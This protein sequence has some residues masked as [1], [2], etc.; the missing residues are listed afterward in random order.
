MSSLNNYSPKTEL[1][2]TK[3]R[4]NKGDNSE[5]GIGQGQGEHLGKDVMRKF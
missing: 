2:L 3:Y 1:E 4:K 5:E